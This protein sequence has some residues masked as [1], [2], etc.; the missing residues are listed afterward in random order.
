M[1]HI[2]EQVQS[3]DFDPVK[4]FTGN[5]DKFLE[6][7]NL[8]WT[9]LYNTE[10][11]SEAMK[12][13]IMQEMEKLFLENPLLSSNIISF[14]QLISSAETNSSK[15]FV[16]KFMRL[17][18]LV[19]T[20]PNLSDTD[21]KKLSSI[22]LAYCDQNNFFYKSESNDE[23]LDKLCGCLEHIVTI[24]KDYVV[25]TE[26]AA[27]L[28]EGQPKIL[29]KFSKR[30]MSFLEGLML[31]EDNADEN[32]TRKLIELLEIKENESES[33]PLA[34][35]RSLR[36]VNMAN[37][38][39]KSSKLG[40]QVN[41]LR[42]FGKSVDAPS[43][44]ALKGSKLGST[45]RGKRQNE[46]KNKKQAAVPIND[47]KS[48]DYVRVD[49][50]VKIDV[51]NLNE[52]QK[53]VLKK[54]REDIP[55]LYQDLTQSLSHTQDFFTNS[56]DIKIDETSEGS[57][58]NLTIS[59]ASPSSSLPIIEENKKD[60]S[61]SRKKKRKNEDESLNEHKK[62]KIA[63][64]SSD[65]T[66]QKIEESTSL[67]EDKEKEIV[68]DESVTET[69]SSDIIEEYV[70]K[71]FDTTP[72]DQEEKISEENKEIEH[73]SVQRSLR[74]STRQAKRRQS[75]IKKD[76]DQRNHNSSNKQ[77]E[78]GNTVKENENA[79]LQLNLK[80][81]EGKMMEE[82]VNTSNEE[83]KHPEEIEENV[84]ERSIRKSARQMKR[85]QEYVTTEQKK[86]KN[87]TEKVQ[88]EQDKNE[89]NNH[90][91]S[92]END[93]TNIEEKNDDNSVLKQE[94]NELV[95]NS[96]RKSKRRIKR[97]QE[98]IETPEKSVEEKKNEQSENQKDD[99]VES[100]NESIEDLLARVDKR[101]EDNK[102][103]EQ[104]KVVEE[105]RRKS[106]R[107]PKK[108][109]Q[110]VERHLN[111]VWNETLPDG[112]QNKIVSLNT[113]TPEERNKHSKKHKM[114]K[115]DLKAASIQESSDDDENQTSS[116]KS[117]DV[118]EF[119][120]DDDF[121]VEDLKKSSKK[122]KKRLYLNRHDYIS[123][124]RKKTKKDVKE[125]GELV[126]PFHVTADCT[127][128]LPLSKSQ[129]LRAVPSP[130]ESE[131]IT[132]VITRS[133]PESEKG[134]KED[135][136]SPQSVD[137]DLGD[138]SKSLSPRRRPRRRLVSP[139]VPANPV[140][141][142]DVIESSQATVNINL[143]KRRSSSRNKSRPLKNITEET[144]A[145]TVKI[146]PP[147]E[148]NANL[149]K[150]R[151]RS[152]SSDSKNSSSDDLTKI[153]TLETGK[154]E[155]YEKKENVNE[156]V[157]PKMKKPRRLSLIETP[158][159]KT[160][161]MKRHKRSKS[162]DKLNLDLEITF[163]TDEMKKMGSVSKHIVEDL[164]DTETVPFDS[165]NLP[166]TLSPV[167]NKAKD[168]LPG[169]PVTC[170]TPDRTT[171][172]LN[173]TSDISPINSGEETT[174]TPKTKYPPNEVTNLRVARL[175]QMVN[176]NV[177]VSNTGRR[178]FGNKH[179]PSSSRVRKMRMKKE[180]NLDILTFSREVP[181]PLTVPASGIL[182]R[183]FNNF[184]ET[185][186][187]SPK[188][189]RV[190]FSDPAI[191]DKKI[192]IKDVEEYETNCD[193]DQNTDS[194]KESPETMEDLF[195]EATDKGENLGKLFLDKMDREELIFT[196]KEFC[197]S[198]LKDISLDNSHFKSALKCL[199]QNL[200]IPE[201]MEVISEYLTNLENAN[202]TTMNDIALIDR[203]TAEQVV[204]ECVVPL[205][206][207]LD[208]F[209]VFLPKLLDV[210][211][212]LTDEKLRCFISEIMRVFG[213]NRINNVTK[214][215]LMQQQIEDHIVNKFDCDK[216]NELIKKYF[217]N[218]EDQKRNEFLVNLM[219]LASSELPVSKE[220]VSCHVNMLQNFVKR[221][222][223]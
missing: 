93:M 159:V 148:V 209:E 215:E 171:E 55:A 3:G 83:V 191:T 54:R 189:K 198:K 97:Q 127:A 81:T 143:S 109:R 203:G 60:S 73:E 58:E 145:E 37:I 100:M 8:K 139:E 147:V 66:M 16:A 166:D 20:L 165:E 113:S 176:S 76:K 155:S 154:K 68:V 24:H 9:K 199:I 219:N 173:N 135:K 41:N 98:E 99:D 36:I 213:E 10:C 187:P 21:I 75:E 57:K 50:E 149:S 126:F 70:T 104:V 131:T 52:H 146:S 157:S 30:L 78:N 79:T 1:N 13:S 85:R 174:V 129:S 162:L 178:W 208:V 19:L 137:T 141:S 172:L 116:D 184:E 101:I 106:K 220:F 23:A 43:P 212:N 67:T 64:L 17:I 195:D 103:T 91:K 123:K 80:I 11:K 65:D 48:S 186:T 6:A 117:G 142:E 44:L 128:P 177:Q 71:T 200:N 46:N 82:D 120:G 56:N 221:M 197:D 29:L 216:M 102:R 192:F 49:T 124:R 194:T 42:L 222:S 181:S 214:E 218:M 204:D 62:S 121:V 94:E 206:Q 108:E 89:E 84:H 69:K 88:L 168:D 53:E 40:D 152:S 27:C 182:K 86:R 22:V 188:R 72:S 122:K 95:E 63:K 193:N 51:N 18:E 118:Y 156:T 150:R 111:D 134:S 35:T 223:D 169:S 33:I 158:R 45:P 47:D 77:E 107:T 96:L 112:N 185:G 132:I 32:N 207:N 125:D 170:D 26:L 39:P 167:E 183:K 202:A 164:A 205:I 34:S 7:L 105:L 38:N 211:Q 201:I 12:F 196:I 59:D 190:N 130:Q 144:V 25:L 119:T 61:A 175:L 87:K 74:K 15:D 92:H 180:E 28:K 153:L 133:P 140:N 110:S 217:L 114:N 5:K 163:L 2:L 138:E 14:L 151:T 161:P 115:L 179:S 31:N 90:K 210:L 4:M 160:K 136:E